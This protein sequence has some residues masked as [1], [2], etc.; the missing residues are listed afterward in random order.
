MRVCGRSSRHEPMAEG[1][2]E[3]IVSLILLRGLCMFL[4]T[5]VTNHHKLNGL[6]TQIYFL[7]VLEVQSPKWVSPTSGCGQQ[8]VVENL[9]TC[10]SSFQRLSLFLGLTGGPFC[11]L[12]SQQCSI[13]Q[14]L[15]Q[16]CLPVTHKGSCDYTEPT[17]MSQDNLSISA[18]ST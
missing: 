18:S 17:W 1:E 13:F 3:D 7:T 9:F 12:Q 14:F 15:S 11:H 5:C 2:G 6:K 16:F 8:V 10:L 4:V